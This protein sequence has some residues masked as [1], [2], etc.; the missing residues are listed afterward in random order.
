MSRSSANTTKIVPR[1]SN[2]KLKKLEKLKKKA[3]NNS[4][5]SSHGSII[6]NQSEENPSNEDETN[7]STNSFISQDEAEMLNDQPNE[8]TPILCENELNT[9][10][11]N[12]VQQYTE[13]DKTAEAETSSNCDTKNQVVT[14]LNALESE[15]VVAITPQV[16]ILEIQDPLEQQ[17]P[18]FFNINSASKEN[19]VVN[20]DYNEDLVEESFDE[21]DKT[22][23]PPTFITNDESIVFHT[24]DNVDV[25]SD[26]KLNSELKETLEEEENL[27]IEKKEDTSI[28]PVSEQDILHE[29]VIKTSEYDDIDEDISSKCLNEPKNEDYQQKEEMLNDTA[30][31]DITVGD[32]SDIV[33]LKISETKSDQVIKI[34]QDFLEVMDSN[35]EHTI[36]DSDSNQKENINVILDHRKY[37]FKSVTTGKTTLYTSRLSNSE[38]NIDF[39]IAVNILENGHIKFSNISNKHSLNLEYDLLSL[40]HISIDHL[41]FLKVFLKSNYSTNLLNNKVQGEV[42]PSVLIFDTFSGTL[43]DFEN[44]RS[45]FENQTPFIRKNDI[46]RKLNLN[47]EKDISFLRQSGCLLLKN[48]K[49]QLVLYNIYKDQ[50]T[51]LKYTYEKK[52]KSFFKKMF[53][54]GSSPRDDVIDYVIEEGHSEDTIVVL[55]KSDIS[56][57]HIRKH[58]DLPDAKYHFDRNEEFDAIEKDE[59]INSNILNSRIPITLLKL[60]KVYST[61]KDYFYSLLIL[62]SYSEYILVNLRISDKFEVL[63]HFELNY[64][65]QKLEDRIKDLNVQTSYIDQQEFYS[66]FIIYKNEIIFSQV[67][68]CHDKNQ[69]VFSDVVI[70]KVGTKVFPG[71]IY[72]V[73]YA[74][75]KSTCLSFQTN[76]G[77]QYTFYQLHLKNKEQPLSESAAYLEFLN[78]HLSN[79]IF[80]RIVDNNQELF[81]SNIDYKWMSL[82]N[83][84]FEESFGNQVEE[85]MNNTSL[86]LEQKS[87]IFEIVLNNIKN[88]LLS[89]IKATSSEFVKVSILSI[90]EHLSNII[91]LIRMPGSTLSAEQSIINS[92]REFNQQ[93]MSSDYGTLKVDNM[94]NV[95]NNVIYESLMCG[96]ELKYRTDIL[97]GV[98]GKCR[99]NSVLFSS[100]VNHNLVNFIAMTQSKHLDFNEEIFSGFLNLLKV[101]Y[102]QNE[103]DVNKVD[104]L[105]VSVGNLMNVFNGKLEL[106]EIHMLKDLTVI[107]KDWVS[108][109]KIYDH[110]YTENKIQYNEYESFFG[111]E[112]DKSIL[113]KCF[114]DLYLNKDYKTKLQ[115]FFDIMSGIDNPGFIKD[116]Y[117]ELTSRER[118]GNVPEVLWAFETLIN[119][120]YKKAFKALSEI[121]SNKVNNIDNKGK[122]QDFEGFKDSMMRLCEVLS[123]HDEN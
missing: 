8:T 66:S 97:K 76:I 45:S 77:G 113:I 85:I 80:N 61:K 112:E 15:D 67:P 25:F 34:K 10:K 114:L 52:S 64:L 93:F 107:N 71:S 31:Q 101:M 17:N 26:D 4:A 49:N 18:I 51:Y 78:F 74:D 14:N 121:E 58:S 33:D 60:N 40:L 94:L 43:W 110:L 46:L 86:S 9:P 3:S 20:K 69:L 7:I 102:Y 41:K 123:S 65:Q 48:E 57:Y 35:T 68:L 96:I 55:F 119:K 104:T 54:Y 88:N 50:I 79:Y 82:N 92:F 12:E 62:T 111:I 47:T 28:N 122:C 42:N 1:P 38:L 98:I 83:S 118:K 109:F 115:N 87:Y 36:K 84:A 29:E 24:E 99:Y 2:K 37:V 100:N 19:A 39:D 91:V 81:D 32:E 108:T 5:S 63:G 11:M 90:L 16:D 116:V 27:T 53:S 73:E 21:P 105:V 89:W 106:H 70:F 13:D 44:I 120:D 72:Q 117:K 22:T 30:V 6:S 95:V 56:M 103:F 75:D 23:L 59:L